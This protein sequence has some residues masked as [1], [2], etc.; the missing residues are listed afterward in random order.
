MVGGILPRAFSPLLFHNKM[1]LLLIFLMDT[2]MIADVPI[3]PALHLMAAAELRHAPL[4]CGC[5]GGP[6]MAGARTS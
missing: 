4:D 6:R 5:F 1:S 3:L 2:N